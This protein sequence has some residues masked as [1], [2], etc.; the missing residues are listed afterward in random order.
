[1][2]F[3]HSTQLLLPLAVIV[4]ARDCRCNCCCALAR[5]ARSLLLLTTITII[6]TTTTKPSLS[7]TPGSAPPRSAPISNLC[8]AQATASVPRVGSSAA[9]P[10]C[11]DLSLS[12]PPGGRRVFYHHRRS[13]SRADHGNRSKPPCAAQ[14]LENSH[15]KNPCPTSASPSHSQRCRAPVPSEVISARPGT[16]LDD[17]NRSRTVGADGAS[18]SFQT[19]LAPT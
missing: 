6:T 7:A 2:R 14:G 9:Q 12:T 15:S 3:Q 8:K 1:M 11:T 13:A 10:S 19:A 18:D 16:P 4:V 5:F 17:V